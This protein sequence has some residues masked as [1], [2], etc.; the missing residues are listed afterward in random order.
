MRDL[1]VCVL[2]FGNPDTVDRAIHSILDQEFKGN[3]EV[4]VVS[5]DT[6]SPGRETAKDPRVRSVRF[7]ERLT[8]GAARN[9]GIEM[10][11][12]RVIAFLAAD[13]VA[14]PGWAQLRLD[15]HRTGHT[16]VSSAIV[17]GGPHNTAGWTYHYARFAARTLGRPPGLVRFPDPAVYSASYDRALLKSLG[18][19]REDLRV[20]EDTDMAVRMMG[21]GEM[22]WFDPAIQTAHFGPRSLRSVGSALAK[23]GEAQGRAEQRLGGDIKRGGRAEVASRTLQHFWFVFGKSMAYSG[24]PRSRIALLAPTLAWG[25]LKTQRARVAMFGPSSSRGIDGGGT[26]S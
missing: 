3:L 18:P 14:M 1:S 6:E 11:T 12:G 26:T 13:C 2:S 20:G 17:N 7:R 25:A 23:L 24:R 21:Q 10:S 8:P 15:R 22:T 9:R 5:L 19:F 16:T 4:V